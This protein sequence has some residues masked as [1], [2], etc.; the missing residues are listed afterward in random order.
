MRVGAEG[1][2]WRG[3]D[4]EEPETIHGT[5]TGGRRP[6][7]SARSGG[8]NPLKSRGNIGAVAVVIAASAY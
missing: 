6:K 2:S 3:H 8:A 5:E 7:A 4:A 1:P